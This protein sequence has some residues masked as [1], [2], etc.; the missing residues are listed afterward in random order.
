MG[1]RCRPGLCVGLRVA[2]PGGG[3]SQPCLL[4][5]PWLGTVSCG[6]SAVLCSRGRPERCSDL[7]TVSQ[8]VRDRHMPAWVA[9]AYP[10]GTVP[11]A[12]E[13]LKKKVN[14][15]MMNTAW[16]MFVF[17]PILI[18]CFGGRLVL[19]S[20]F[21]AMQSLSP[22][23]EC[24]VTIITHSSLQLLGSNNPCLSFPSGWDCMRTPPCLPDV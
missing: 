9:P 17:K 19:F 8:A 7:P 5:S 20:F 1:R 6:P 18:K 23:Q 12:C 14:T 22:R 11:G 15:I 21:V 13:C 10:V 4:R 3:W 2:I 16:I 24:S